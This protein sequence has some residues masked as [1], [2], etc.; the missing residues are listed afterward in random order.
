MKNAKLQAKYFKEFK[1]KKIY[2]PTIFWENL[3]KKN[4][5]IIKGQI[6]KF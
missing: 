1:T 4:L 5:T 6:K 3:I 2:S